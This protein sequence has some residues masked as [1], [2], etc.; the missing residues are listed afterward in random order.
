MK[1]LQE[2][3]PPSCPDS[4]FPP[5]DTQSA[6]PTMSSTD[7]IQAVLFFPTGSTGGPDGLR[8]QH[9][10]DLVSYSLGEGPNRLITSLTVFVNLVI[11]G[12]VPISVRPFF[13]GATLT[14]L[15]K[16]NGG[17]RPLAVGCVLRRLAAKCPCTSVFHEIGCLLFPHQLGFGTAL[18]AEAAVHTARAFLPNLEDGH[19]IIKLDFRNAFNSIRRDKMLHSVLLKAPE[20]LP[21]AYCSYRYPSLLFLG[22]FSISSKEGVQQGDPLGPL[23][24]CLAIYDIIVNPCMF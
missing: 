14:C 8:P 6:P 3:H 24:F 15:G 10:K 21:F 22:D 7:V 16:K 12:K 2:K 9:L 11:C 17:V 1:L 19:L 5:L 4:F 23:L 13:F 20:L 18:G